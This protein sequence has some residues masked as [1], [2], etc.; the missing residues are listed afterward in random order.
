MLAA[1][2][3]RIVEGRSTLLQAPCETPGAEPIESGIAAGAGLVVL[4]AVMDDV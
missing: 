4:D 2:G 3:V 1:A